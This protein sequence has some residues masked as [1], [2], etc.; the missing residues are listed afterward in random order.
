MFFYFH[1]SKMVQDR[2][3]THAFNA[4]SI[5][6]W[7]SYDEHVLNDDGSS[8]VQ[9]RTQVFKYFPR[10]RFHKIGK[11]NGCCTL[12]MSGPWKPTWKEK[13]DNGDVVEYNWNRIEKP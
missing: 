6:L 12:L 3:H 10:E 11:G 13:L 2:F 9:T 7:G 8:S 4:I 1:K 5:K